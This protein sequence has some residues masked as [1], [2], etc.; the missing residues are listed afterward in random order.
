LFSQKGDSDLRLLA[1]ILFCLLSLASA[2]A[3]DGT[4]PEP[5]NKP[6]S[7]EKHAG[8]LRNARRDVVVVTG[9]YVP[10]PLE[11]VNRSVT[12]QELGEDEKLLSN[13]AVDF[14][15]LD[16]SID[17][18]QRGP[19]NIQGD[20]SIRGSTFG[21][22]L[23]LVDGV[24]M[25]DVQSGHHNM[26]LP[27]PIESLEKI[28]VLKGSGSALYGSDAVGGVV[29]FITRKPEASEIRMRLGVG[30]HGTNQQRGVVSLVKGIFSEQVTFSRDFSSGFIEN[31]DY[32][33]LSLTSRTQIETPIGATRVVLAHSDR[34]FGAEQYYGNFNSWERT[35]GWFASAQQGFGERTDV[36]F[37][38]RRHT[39]LFVLFRDRPQ[40]FTNR[41]AVESYQ[42]GVR[43]WEKLGQNGRLH[44]GAEGLHDSIDSNNLGYHKRTRGSGYV[45]ADILALNRFSFTLG[46]RLEVYSSLET[47][48][49]PTAAMGVWL[50][51]RLKLRGSISRAFRLPTFTDLYY[52]DPANVGSPDL[53]PE[54]AWSYEAGVDYN[55]GGKY[56]AEFTIFHR[57]EKN[58]IDFVRFSPDDLWRAT[59]FQQLNFTG[60]EA[61]VT[62]VVKRRHRLDVH[63]TFL[64]GSQDL[65]PGYASRYVF[66]YP[67]HSAVVSW[68]AAL[69][70]SI[71]ARTRVGLL[72]RYKRDPY[73][74][75]DVYVARNKGR[76]NPFVQLTN[77]TGTSYQEIPGVVMPGRGILGG[78]EVVFLTS[79]K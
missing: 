41:H 60:F 10:V 26:D 37:A 78:V 11:E 23:V 1:P 12:V 66:N 62:T 72:Q 44:Y 76:I 9:S 33:N 69:P 73:G 39:D 6:D 70:G 43:R 49:S 28:E 17:L 55:A 16:P 58:G 54:S 24:R 52:H 36:S 61:G 34:P 77:L 53:Q 46:G 29:N 13:T 45:A 64:E 5:D 74:L 63:Y 19:N 22:T 25:N 20:L 40:V 57:R 31:R 56:R 32:R 15:K 50:T 21:Q 67:R 75:W 79:R 65:I 30:N 8:P 47:Q 27:V 59:N 71:V 3:Q 38:Y 14:L 51:P 2:W 35:K 18:R 42:V 68:Q 7:R 48:F 4:P